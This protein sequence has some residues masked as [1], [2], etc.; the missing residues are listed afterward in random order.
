[1]KRT[2]FTEWTVL[3]LLALSP[4]L[5]AANDLSDAVSWWNFEDDLTDELAAA[6][7]LTQYGSLAYD[8]AT[9]KVGANSLKTVVSGGI[10]AAYCVDGDLDAGTPGKSGTS[11]EVM[12]LAL[13]VNFAALPSSGTAHMMVTKGYYVSP[14][15]GWSVM[16][17][18]LSGT[19]EWRIGKGNSGGTAAQTN[20]GGGTC[21]CVPTNA[22]T[23]GQWYHVTVTY[24]A[25]GDWT[26]SAYDLTNT[27][28]DHANGNWSD[29]DGLPCLAIPLSIGA[30]CDDATA[31]TFDSGTTAYFDEVVIWGR[32]LSADEIDAVRAGTYAPP[33][34]GSSVPLI[35]YRSNQ[36]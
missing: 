26:I 18:N 27:H 34:G 2:R 35:Y 20:D 10:D 3:T 1:M 7:D 32:V 4:S 19:L 8:E 28:D 24:A 9:Y 25:N 12:T 16:V 29:D 22:I 11:N 15:I 17:F 30:R 21:V 5:W 36:Q 13:W 6:N 31:T 33:G 23:T 14:L